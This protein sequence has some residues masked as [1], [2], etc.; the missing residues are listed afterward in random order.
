MDM[1]IQQK[2]EDIWY[3]FGG[4]HF[5]FGVVYLVCKIQKYKSTKVQNTTTQKYKKNDEDP[6]QLCR[7]RAPAGP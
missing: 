2:R 4:V 3:I 6:P 1:D 7:S 5:V